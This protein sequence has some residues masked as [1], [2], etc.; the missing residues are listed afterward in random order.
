[1]APWSATSFQ[2]QVPEIYQLELTNCCQLNCPACIRL[3]TRV[4]RP[5]GFL[6]LGLLKMMLD[7]GDFAGSYFVE[8]QMAGEPLLHPQLQQIIN[9]LRAKAP[10]LKLGLSTNGILIRQKLT[11]LSQLD[12]VTVSLD[13]AD[14]ATYEAQ[15]LRGGFDNLLEAI[16][17]LRATKGP[18]IDLQV[19]NFPGAEDEL[20]GLLHLATERGWSD[21]TCRSV[22]DCFAAYQGRTYD[23]KQKQSLCLNPWL[24]VSIQW[25]G[26]VVPCCFSFGTAIDYGNVGTQSLAGSWKFSPAHQ[27]LCDQM[28]R[29]YN[30]DGFP[31]Q[32]C[33][34]RSPVL[35]HQTM[36]MQNQRR[37][38]C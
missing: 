6:D 12:L 13:S 15:R 31:C 9:M 33:Y 36:L 37:N 22:P 26:D 17:R 38:S 21:V 14:R 35:F 32:L 34:M 2:V 23:V 10:H 19:I 29:H 11:E 1:M 7:K 27:E 28:R 24:S 16:E 25:D 3:D 5:L 18:Q 4:K 30:L 8:F 20:P